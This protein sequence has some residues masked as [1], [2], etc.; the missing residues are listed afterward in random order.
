MPAGGSCPCRRADIFL[1]GGRGLP[2][3]ADDTAFTAFTAA[4][5]RGAMLASSGIGHSRPIG[6]E[7]DE[8]DRDRLPAASAPSGELIRWT[9]LPGVPP[10]D[11][12]AQMRGDPAGSG[13]AAL[14]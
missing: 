14:G 10:P 8:T 9:K 13:G 5:S 11:M 1:A 7:A 2:I 4:P 6:A 12:Q 3:A